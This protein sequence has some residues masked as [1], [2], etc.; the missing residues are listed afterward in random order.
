MRALL[1]LAVI[2][3]I[4]T[5]PARAAADY[6][7]SR[8]LAVDTTIRV[9]YKY[10]VDFHTIASCRPQKGDR[11]YEGNSHHRWVCAWAG[12]W[13]DLSGRIYVCSG[14]YLITGVRGRITPHWF[15]L[16]FE[17]CSKLISL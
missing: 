4:L 12:Q 5:M 10:H 3:S 7:V 8:P 6:Y 17:R 13:N 1:L 14:S 9:A 16:Q 15:P 11:A 2:V